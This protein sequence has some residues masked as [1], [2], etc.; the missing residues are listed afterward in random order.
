MSRFFWRDSFTPSE[1][2]RRQANPL[3]TLFF[4][5]RAGDLDLQSTSTS[6][7]PP[8]RDPRDQSQAM[9]SH[10]CSLSR[11]A[12][13]LA[14]LRR[15]AISSPSVPGSTITAAGRAPAAAAVTAQTRAKSSHLRPQD[16]GVL[17]RLLEDIPKFGRKGTLASFPPPSGP[18]AAPPSPGSVLTWRF[19]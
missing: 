5:P 16:R 14:G 17:V 18:A 19:P 15:L 10:G 7:P 12:T 4:A 11:P 6:T 1:V 2:A 3:R 8:P 13:C 9:A